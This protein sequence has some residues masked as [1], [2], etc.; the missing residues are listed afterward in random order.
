MKV[1]ISSDKGV[2]T[3]TK[4]DEKTGKVLDSTIET[5]NVAMDEKAI[6]AAIAQTIKTSGSRRDA[7]CSFLGMLYG[8]QR[9]DGFKGT[10][11]KDTGKL[12]AEF[13]AAVRDVESLIVR[14]MVEHGA[15]KLPAGKIA[16]GENDDPKELKIQAFL[17]QLRDDKNYS[18]AKNTTSR[19]YALVGAN[20]VTQAGFIVPFPVMQAQINATV[21]RAPADNSIAGKL[22]AI[23]E[24]M[25]KG[26]IDSADAIDSLS[27]A[28]ALFETL[29][30]VVNHYAEIATAAR[31]GIDSQAQLAVE[32]AKQGSKAPKRQRATPANR[33]IKAKEQAQEQEAATV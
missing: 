4:I 11:D 7:F 14:E 33:P 31:T 10:A 1:E 17:Q 6:G 20:C 16:A 29:Q 22:R 32:S 2:Y 26:T 5:A 15:I 13:K 30:G 24:A 21:H 12:S 18:N 28:K 27:L 23:K 3:I 19:Y 8:H 25:D 9:L